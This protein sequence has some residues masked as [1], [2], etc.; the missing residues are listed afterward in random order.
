MVKPQLF[1]FAIYLAGHINSRVSEQRNVS[2]FI[3]CHCVTN[4]FEQS[5]ELIISGCGLDLLFQKCTPGQLVISWL[6]LHFQKC[7]LIIRLQYNYPSES[8]CD[9]WLPLG[10]KLVAFKSVIAVISWLHYIYLIW[11]KLLPKTTHCQNVKYITVAP[12]GPL[13]TKTLPTW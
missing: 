12:H 3:C 10:S 1:G 9:P 4:H 6:W 13:T 7:T 2:L 11:H 5:S 8:N